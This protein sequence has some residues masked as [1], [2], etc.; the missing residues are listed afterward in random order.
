MPTKFTHNQTA[1]SFKQIAVSGEERGET[2]H[3]LFEVVEL[4]VLGTGEL[5]EE[6]QVALDH[7]LR[8]VGQGLEQNWKGTAF[9]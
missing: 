5:S 4:S 1:A 8:G 2:S 3:D 9:R 7:L 6:F